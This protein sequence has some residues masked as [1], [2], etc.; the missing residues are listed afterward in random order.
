MNRF[1]IGV[2]AFAIAF[3]VAGCGGNEK[4]EVPKTT[5]EP[6]KEPLTILTNMPDDKPK[7]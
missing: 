2:L 4:A 1:P 6:P 3:A 5:V 7:K